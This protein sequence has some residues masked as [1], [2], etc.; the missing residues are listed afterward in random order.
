M[1]VP[2]DAVDSD[3][4]KRTTGVIG[5]VIDYATKADGKWVDKPGS[6][7]FYKKYSLYF[8]DY[9]GDHP[10][11]L[12]V[13]I[14]FSVCL[15]VLD[16][17]MSVSMQHCQILNGLLLVI[18][19]VQLALMI[20]LQP[21]AKPL[22]RQVFILSAAL[23]ILSASL[24]FAKSMIDNDESETSKVLAM[25]A[26]IVIVLSSVVVCLKTVLAGVLKVKVIQEWLAKKFGSR[27]RKKNF[28]AVIERDEASAAI[29]FAVAY[30]SEAIEMLEE[31]LFHGPAHS[32]PKPPAEARAD[33]PA[34][35]YE[36]GYDDL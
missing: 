23:Q 31:G 29:S 15:A 30:Q 2:F 7:G 17:Q 33:P 14:C 11:F 26:V 22:S 21:V 1:W 10:G 34:Q 35:T 12:L 9:V 19:V 27:G 36:I 5:R 28:E 3:D 18:L 6:K 16:F 24:S 32:E 13:E 4:D 8:K 20:K 25:I